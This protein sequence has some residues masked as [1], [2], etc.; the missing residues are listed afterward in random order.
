MTLTIKNKLI[1]IGGIVVIGLAIL[2]TLGVVNSNK[3]LELQNMRAALK[4]VQISML[5][6]RRAEKDFLLR[7]DIKYKEVYSKTSQE[8]LDKV[9]KLKS[10][11]KSLNIPLDKINSIERE[12]QKYQTAYNKL[13]NA[14]IKKGLDKDSGHYGAL[15]SATHDI[16]ENMITIN[17]L[18]SQVLLLT[19]RRHEKDFMLRGDDKYIEEIK[20]TAAQLKN[21][22]HSTK[23]KELLDIYLNEIDAFF[24][25][26]QE[27]GLTP[28]LGI[29]GEMRNAVHEVEVDLK[30]A[31]SLISKHIKEGIDSASLQSSMVTLILSII[32]ITII[33]FIARQIITP[34][35]NFSQ[36]I[37][38][39]RSANDLSQRIHEPND[40][41]GLVAREFNGFMDHFQRLIINI[42]SI[43]AS[44]RESTQVVSNSVLKTTDGLMNQAIESDMVATAITEMGSAANEIAN[45]AHDTKNK[46]DQAVANASIGQ[47]RL[48]STITNINQLSE[49]LVTAGQRVNFLQEKS[50]GIT[51]VLE[52]I[53]SIADQTNLLSLNAAIEAARAGEQGRGFAVVADEV[54]TLAVRTQNSTTE[55]SNIIDELQSTTID[56]VNTVNQCKDQGL[57]SASQAKETE[58]IL[59]EIISDVNHIADMTVEVATAVEEQSGVIQEVDRNI[60]RIRDIGEQVSQDSQENS[61]ASAQVAKLAQTLHQE[62]KVF[63]I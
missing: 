51:S 59:N 49:E 27:I 13:V 26:N 62:A 5:Q 2:F 18:S 53:K 12:L 16:E 55:I 21:Q 34:L 38:S 37:I 23:T 4:D 46:T 3:I 56:I 10:D 7:K 44:L 60:I 19:L 1:L 45:N 31:V 14:W 17:D 54:R 39:I 29:Q 52:V 48:D 43:V 40:E 6:L 58:N 50:N 42:N 61:K 41:I 20:I 47:N 57:E 22:L 63:T 11:L 8:L 35:N 15:R 9:T 33:F 25:I 28:K 32:I 30:L 36:H 24:I